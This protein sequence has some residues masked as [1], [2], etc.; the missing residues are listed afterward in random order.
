MIVA[1]RIERH[2]GIS[3]WLADKWREFVATNA[4]SVDH[5]SISLILYSN[6]GVGNSVLDRLKLPAYA[7]QSIVDLI[8]DDQP[9]WV[10]PGAGRGWVDPARPL[11]DA[12]L[13]RLAVAGQDGAAGNPEAQA[14]KT[15]AG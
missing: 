15:G 13:A 3:T 5:L 6:D 9:P 4:K 14:F 2:D 8:D 11:G 7:V 1:I 10:R 12:G